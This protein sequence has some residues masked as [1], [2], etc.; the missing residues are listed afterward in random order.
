MLEEYENKA[1]EFVR[2]VAWDLHDPENHRSAIRIIIAVLHTIRDILTVEES[3]HLISQLPMLIKG[4][5]VHEWHL[6]EKKKIK[7]KAEFFS[8]LSSHDSQMG[9]VHFDIEEKAMKNVEA[10]IKTL[11]R[12]VTP[13]QI[14]NIIG[15]FPSELKSIWFK[16]VSMG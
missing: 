16:S 14:D 12:H 7:D 13:G 10:V 9:Q 1:R 11:K 3:L 8:R 15:Q 6:G 5:Y 2:E 4:F